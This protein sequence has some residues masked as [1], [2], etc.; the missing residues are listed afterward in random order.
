MVD[1]V[2]T[3]IEIKSGTDTL[4]RLLDLPIRGPEKHGSLKVGSLR[5]RVISGV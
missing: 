3:G 2:L 4:E 1:G 5:L